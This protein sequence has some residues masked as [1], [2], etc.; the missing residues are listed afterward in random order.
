MNSNVL[1]E[2]LH[3]ETSVGGGEVDDS[4]APDP[5][6]TVTEGREGGDADAEAVEER[7]LHNANGLRSKSELKADDGKESKHERKRVL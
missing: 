6:I 7:P 5:Q 2:Q 1:D 4:W 3:H